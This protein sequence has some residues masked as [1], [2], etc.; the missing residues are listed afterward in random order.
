MTKGTFVFL[1][2]I[3]LCLIPYLGIPSAWKQYIYLGL[4]VILIL[5]GYM[6]RRARYLTDIDRGNGERG[7]E[8]FVETTQNLFGEIK[9]E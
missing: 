5:I 6:I 3:L 9:V 8:T 2:G 7:G 1:L 4:G